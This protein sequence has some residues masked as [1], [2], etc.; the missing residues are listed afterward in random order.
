VVYTRSVTLA[1]PK[2]SRSF[3]EIFIGLGLH[4]LSGL[5]FTILISRSLG[6]AFFGVFSALMSL[7][8]IF[9][10]LGDFGLSAT[11]IKYLP[12]PKYGQKLLDHVLAISLAASLFF[13][14]TSLIIGTL[15]PWLVPGASF[16]HYLLLSLLASVYLHIGLIQAYLTSSGGFWSFSKLQIMDGG[17]KLIT[18]ATLWYMGFSLGITQ[19]MLINLTTASLA[20]LVTY[21]QTNLHIQIRF[22]TSIFVR[23]WSYTSWMALG[24]VFT[25]FVGRVDTVLINLFLG[26]Y[27]TG[28]YAVAHKFL[29]VL[30]LLVSG[31]NTFLNNRFSHLHRQHLRS[32]FLK[33]FLVN[34]AVSTLVI[35]GFFIVAPLAPL[36]FGTAYS[37]SVDYIGPL[38]LSSLP[39]LLSL[40][41]IAC[42]LYYFAEAR[43]VNL[44]SA[45][46]VI[47]LLSLNFALIPTFG[48]WGS[49]Y[50]NLV[51]NL[52][53]FGAT[54]LLVW[55]RLGSL[56]ETPQKL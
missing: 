9:Y 47:V 26:S 36:V 21:S 3:L 1:L 13:I 10:T 19:L 23:L 40:V 37:G 54:T 32:Y 8:S 17:L 45:L 43:L 44:I 11:I 7:M 18:V 30:A 25:T 15:F 14:T 49:I 27:L 33:A 35:L 31:I 24:R 39:Y 6:P 29:L 12:R 28:I 50:A 46:Q 42:L 22:S 56:A 51:G 52:V 38:G 16:V 4:T 5:V 34:A 53:L 55:K 41:N 48:I 20:L 2:S